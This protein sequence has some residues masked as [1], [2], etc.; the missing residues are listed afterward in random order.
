M[1]P[2]LHH[3]VF[4][5]LRDV[6]YFNQARIVFGAMTWLHEQDIAPETLLA[7]LTETEMA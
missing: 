6:H 2:Y 5:E 3:G 4:R 1:K 7:G